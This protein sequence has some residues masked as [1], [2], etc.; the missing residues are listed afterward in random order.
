[1]RQRKMRAARLVEPGRWELETVPVPRPGAGQVLIRIEGS[2]ICS[3]NLPAWEG[4]EWFSY[5]FSPGRL[6]HEGWGRVEEP[7]DS[8]LQPGARVACLT[9]CAYAEYDVAGPEAVVPLPEALDGRPFPGEPLACLVNILRRI[10]IIKGSTV[11]VVGIGFLGALLCKLLC[12]QGMRV[13]GVSR[14]SLSRDWA[15][16]MG[17]VEALPMEDHQHVIERIKDLTNENMC[18]VVVEAVGK[19]RPLDLAAELTA[20]R[21]QLVIAGYHQDG[22][23]SVNMQLWNWRGLDVANAHERDPARYRAGLL[24][25]VELAARGELDPG[26]LL[27]H[28][29]RLDEMNDALA[30]TG[31]RPAGFMKAVVL[32]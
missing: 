14:R 29:F 12:D 6:G 26:P 31:E 16:R 13:I 32:V 1:M 9:N 24:E 18:D 15:H 8:G 30:A 23:R 22:L 4:R 17:A 5:P 10:R 28:T 21:G 20:I 11:A 3:S 2:G 27:T 19:Q 25:A 7:G